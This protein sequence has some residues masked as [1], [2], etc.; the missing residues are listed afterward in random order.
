MFGHR[1]SPSGIMPLLI[2]AVENHISQYGVKCF[3]VGNYGQF[4][5]LAASAVTFCKKTHPEISLLMLLP[6]HPTERPVKLS[7]E[8]D[9]SYYPPDMETV[10]R[11]IAIVRANQCAVDH[12]GY[13]I[14]YM[15]RSAGN[16]ANLLAYAQRRGTNGR[17]NITLLKRSDDL[18]SY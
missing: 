18:T 3:I 2:S 8:F 16:T 5:K 14:A 7:C 6:Y 9:G 15:S 11:K 1:D 10:P 13:I 4:D 17:K 12:S